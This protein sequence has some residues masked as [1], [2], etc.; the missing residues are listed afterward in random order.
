MNTRA[1]YSGAVIPAHK[2]LEGI[3][4]CGDPLI[5]RLISH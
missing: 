3:G 5:G 4:G 2:R 1:L